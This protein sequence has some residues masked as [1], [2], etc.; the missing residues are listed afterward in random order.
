LVDCWAS[1]VGSELQDTR[2]ATTKLTPIRWVI[3]GSFVYI[4]GFNTGRAVVGHWSAR[5]TT[6][7]HALGR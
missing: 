4:D 7:E 3:E 5:L 2:H 6:I 1:D